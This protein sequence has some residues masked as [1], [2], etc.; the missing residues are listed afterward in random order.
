[1]EKIQIKSLVHLFVCVILI[2]YLHSCSDSIETSRYEGP[3]T[4]DDDKIDLQNHLIEVIDMPLPSNSEIDLEKTVIVGKQDEWI[5]RLTMTNKNSIDVIY[6][7][8]VNEM[9]KY[10]FK[11]K[12][13]V[14][15]AESSLIFQNKKK[16]IFI[17]L[18]KVNF[19][20]SN[21]EITSTPLN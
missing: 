1:M 13:S 17:K 12:S 7:F 5:G 2:I 18:S 20:R 15:S 8:F 11:E 4:E 21:I 9:P 3:K 16:T 10:K 19:D 14:R 6:S